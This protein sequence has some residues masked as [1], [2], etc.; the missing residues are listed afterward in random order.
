MFLMENPEL[1]FMQAVSVF[2][3]TY[4][5]EDVHYLLSASRKFPTHIQQYDKVQDTFFWE[6]DKMMKKR[7]EEE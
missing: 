3:W 6:C 4:V 7:K 1:R 2:L 5:S